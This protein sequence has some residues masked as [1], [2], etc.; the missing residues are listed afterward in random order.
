MTR[1]YRQWKAHTAHPNLRIDYFENIDSKDKAYWLGFLF[2][3]G[4]LMRDSRTGKTRIGIALSR[5]DEDTIDRFISCLRL[6]KDRKFYRTKEGGSEQVVVH[7]GCLKMSNDLMSHGM[8]I[9]KSKIIEYPRLESRELELSFLLGYYDA[10]GVQN[11][12]II[13]SGSA[14]FLK[15]VRH[16]FNLAYEIYS[17]ESIGEICGKKTRGTKYS[18]SLGAELLRE[19]MRDYD[20]SMPRK[21]WLPCSEEERMHRVRKALTSE[22]VRK[23]KGQQIRWRAITPSK[24]AKLVC[25]V[26]LKQIAVKFN[27]TDTAVAKKCRK[28][29]IPSLG[30]GYWRRQRRLEKK[31]KQGQ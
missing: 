11:R 10:D 1:W 12:T 22:E 15:E 7:F 31:S 26:P 21:R 3:D 5:K 24:L 30:R 18:I 13:I 29:N 28:F 6:D 8:K 16:R 23:R 14:Q 27:V 2:G 19:M 25:E 20:Q 4:Y 9:G 17:K